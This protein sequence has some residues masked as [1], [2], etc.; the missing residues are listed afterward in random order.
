[1]RQEIV[2]G[3]KRKGL[4][5]CRLRH[6][7]GQR[8]RGGCVREISRKGMMVKFAHQADVIAALRIGMQQGMQLGRSGQGQHPEPEDQRHARQ[9]GQAGPLMP[10]RCVRR[11]HASA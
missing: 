11:I 1:M 4:D 7:E 2:A 3:R 9:G 8:R 10:L 6:T 5:E